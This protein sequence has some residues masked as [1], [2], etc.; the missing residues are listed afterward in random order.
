MAN[1]LSS[2]DTSIKSLAPSFQTAIKTIIDAESAPLNR[3]QTQ[4]DQIDVR[5]GVYTDIKTNFDALQS[6]IQTLISTQATY[7][8]A[9]VSKATVTPSTAGTTVLSAT[10]TESAAAADYDIVVTQLAK[11]QAKSTTAAFSPDVALGKSGTFW[12][13]GN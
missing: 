6:A 5:R 10:S 8:M 9:T 7:G 1:T 3:V 2:I 4:K 11:A 12:L 13:G